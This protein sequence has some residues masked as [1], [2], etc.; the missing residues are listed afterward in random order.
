M[1]HVTV[2]ASVQTKQNGGSHRQATGRMAKLTDEE[3]L[4]DREMA[5]FMKA[6]GNSETLDFAQSLAHPAVSERISKGTWTH[7]QLRGAWDSIAPKEGQGMGFEV[8][9]TPAGPLRCLF[10]K[11]T[12]APIDIVGISA[13]T[14]LSGVPRRG[15]VRGPSGT[16]REGGRAEREFNPENRQDEG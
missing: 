7:E 8:G 9:S 15:G 16:T 14:A 10:M 6:S 4:L 13:F 5:A 1:R 2:R 11:I 3:H 12:G